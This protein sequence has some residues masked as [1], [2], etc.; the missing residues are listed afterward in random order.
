MQPQQLEPSQENNRQI[1]GLAEVLKMMGALYEYL[2]DRNTPAVTWFHFET[3]S[4]LR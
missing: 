1:M 3:K 4:F 2:G